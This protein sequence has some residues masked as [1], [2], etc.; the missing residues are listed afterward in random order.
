[1]LPSVVELGRSRALVVG[2]VLRGFKRTLILQVRG[3][4]G[5]P[6]GMVPDPGLDA[7]A[8]RPSLDRQAGGENLVRAQVATE[9]VVKVFVEQHLHKLCW[10]R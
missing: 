7:G 2:D 10:C 9:P 5:C 3:D 4:P 6:E 8:A 1:M